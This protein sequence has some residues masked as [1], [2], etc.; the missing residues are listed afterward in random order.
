CFSNQR[1][2]MSIQPDPRPTAAHTQT[3]RCTHRH[4]AFWNRIDEG[5]FMWMRLRKVAWLVLVTLIPALI[6]QARG[7]R[8]RPEFQEV[9]D[10]HHKAW[11]GLGAVFDI[12]QSSEGYL[13]LTTSRGVLRFDGV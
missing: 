3:S 8:A 2:S 4:L 7:A 11:N 12:K 1:Y 9:R 6:S 10:F 5:R 13:W